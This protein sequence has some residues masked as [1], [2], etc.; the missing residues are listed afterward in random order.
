MTVQLYTEI[1][2][3][4]RGKIVEKRHIETRATE[5]GVDGIAYQA[6]ISG[7][8]LNGFLVELENKRAT[9]MAED[10]NDE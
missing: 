7:D 6:K 1:I 2:E 8:T 5:E 3:N 4:L 10:D 9:L